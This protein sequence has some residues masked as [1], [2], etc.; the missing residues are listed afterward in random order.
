MGQTTKPKSE[1]QPDIKQQM[2]ITKEKAIKENKKLAKT[3]TCKEIIE[4]GNR[5]EDLVKRKTPEILSDPNLL[6]N[7]VKEVQQNGVAGEEDTIIALIIV[8]TTRLVKQAI[9]ESRNLFLSD[10]TGVGKDF[11][12]KKTV[13]VILPAPNY[14]HERKMTPETFT[15]WHMNEPDWTWDEKVIQIEDITENLLNSSTFKTMASG[16]TKATVVIKQKLHEIYINGKPVMVC[17]SHHA[18]LLDEGLRRFPIGGMNNTIEQTRRIKDKTARQYTG[19][20]ENNSDDIFRAA[21]RSLK[22]YPVIIPFAEII[23]FYFPDDILMRTHFNRFL[24]YI[25]ASAVFHQYQREKTEDE[26]IIATADDY[27]IARMVLIYTTSNPKMIPLSKEYRDAIEILKNNEKEMTVN[28]V[29][30]KGEKSKDWYYRNLPSLKEMKLLIRSKKWDDGANRDVD[31]YQY[32]LF[33][34]MIVPTWNAIGKDIDKIYKNTKK[35]KKTEEVSLLEKW[36]SDN[37]IKPRKPNEEEE[38]FV[39]VFLGHAIT[40]NRKVFLHFLHLGSFLHKRDEKRYK[41]YYEERPVALEETVIS[42]F[43]NSSDES[44]NTSKSQHQRMKELKE[45]LQRDKLSDTGV[46]ETALY[47]NFLPSDINQAIQSGILTRLPN[48]NLKWGG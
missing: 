33:N 45:Y 1:K 48:G 28:E 37:E 16:G 27:M 32:A 35:T 2:E 29:Y 8:A 40:F 17:T 14:F 22:P 42:D 20:K 34:P 18:N 36:F 19:R 13:E 24:D 30:Q 10:T 7:T 6:I 41:C 46:S 4:E 26:A 9:P 38:E 3:R 21:V 44:K 31:T 39:V 5:F 15:Y 25:C 11:T 12:T 43:G 47:D 23:Q